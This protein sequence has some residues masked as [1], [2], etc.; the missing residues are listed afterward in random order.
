MWEDNLSPGN[1]RRRV[2]SH[3]WCNLEGERPVMESLNPL[4][5]GGERTRAGGN[6]IL[7]TSKALRLSPPPM[8]SKA[9]GMFADS[10]RCEHWHK[11]TG[12]LCLFLGTRNTNYFHLVVSCSSC[13]VTRKHVSDYASQ[14]LCVSSWLCVCCPLFR[15]YGPESLGSAHSKGTV[16]RDNI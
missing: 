15:M 12:R 13:L 7:R 14:W 11:K 6:R 1:Q 10:C 2:S 8:F 16:R 5:P 3:R 4:E 9:P